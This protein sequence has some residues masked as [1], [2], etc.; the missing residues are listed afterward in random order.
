MPELDTS[1]RLPQQAEGD[2]DVLVDTYLVVYMSYRP[3][4]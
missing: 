1:W 2:P 4:Q 3:F